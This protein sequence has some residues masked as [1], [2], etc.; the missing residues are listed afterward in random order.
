MPD[1]HN[2][3]TRSYNMSRIRSKNTKPEMLIR[4]QLFAKGFRFRLH[5]KDLPGKPDIVLRKY[6]TSVFVHGCFWHGHENCKFF[7]VPQTRTEWW[8]QKIN[9]NKELDDINSV[10]LKDLGW[11]V[12]HIYECELKKDK[13]EKT[14]KRL[15][16]KLKVK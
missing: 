1:V 16:D 7:V 3:E 8:M 4:K 5:S 10:K 2:A 6:K 12:V 11:Q 14:V 13:I 15:I 9:R